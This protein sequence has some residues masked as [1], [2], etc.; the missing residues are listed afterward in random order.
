MK[1]RGRTPHATVHGAG[2]A[3]A[4]KLQAL[5]EQGLRRSEK[6]DYA[7]AASLFRQVVALRPDLYQAHYNLGRALAGLGRD[8]EALQALERVLALQPNHLKATRDLAGLRRRQGDLAGALRLSEHLARLEP[9]NDQHLNRLGVVLF[10]IGRH[11]EAEGVTRQALLL[12]PDLAPYHFNL[13]NIIRALHGD[14]AALPHYARAVELD[15]TYVRGLASLGAAYYRTSPEKAEH[16]FRRA[17]A[18]D[19]DTFGA[20]AGVLG[21]ELRNCDFDATEEVF[22]MTLAA[23]G[24]GTHHTTNWVNAA[25]LSY[26]SLFLPLGK[27][28]VRSLQDH[29]A[30]RLDGVVRIQVPLPEAPAAPVATVSEHR[31]IRIGYLS[32][33]FGDHPVGHV[34]L[35]LFPAHDRERFEVHA[36]STRRGGSDGSEY[37]RAH[38]TSFDAFHEVGGQ[39]SREIAVRIRAAGIDILID[40]DGYMD[41]TSPPILAYRPAPLQVF[42]L[43]HAGGLGL[44]WV[45]YL[46]ADARVIPHGEEGDFREAVV[47]LPEIYHCAD[48]HPITQDCPPRQAWNLPE[49]GVV[50]CVFNNP[51]KI[52]RR[53][54]D[55]WMRILAAV[56]GSVL[57]LSSFRQ[58]RD[59]LLGNLRRHAE[60]HG[61]DPQRLII[62]ERVPNKAM[63]LARLGHADLMLDTLTLNASTTALDGLWAGV[64]LLAVQGDRF[65]N[66]ISTTMLHAIGLDDLVCA[67]LDEYE[68]RAIQLG[69]DPAARAELRRRLWANRETTPLFDIGRF[70]RNLERAYETMWARYCRGEAPA[71]F[72]LPT[73]ADT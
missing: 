50:Y 62:S 71:G 55:C 73:S 52:D 40:L 37:A 15:P 16:Y 48:R 35:S 17:L 47:R 19:P 12:K 44:P 11:A 6:G 45:D 72:D 68:R 36:F 1:N 13:G 38:R 53:V 49:D 24:R 4:A 29:I 65:S 33:N 25:N 67:D 43:G 56:D 59:R 32:P 20:L 26:Q 61:V 41:T 70:T 5:F 3:S 21:I 58:D 64:P 60:R 30:T 34:T 7:G 28:A 31:R 22:A 9:H 27:Q 51:D 66:R 46:V 23:L 39:S 14:T 8:G 18:L 2:K 69:H 10:E 57:W 42:W 63:H 54:F